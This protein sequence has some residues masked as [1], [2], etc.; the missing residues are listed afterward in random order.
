MDPFE[1]LQ[2]LPHAGLGQ[3]PTPLQKLRR[4][5]EAVGAEIWAKRDDLQDFALAGNKVRKYNLVLGK[6]LADGYDTLVTTGAVQSNSARAGAAA[7]AALGI[8]CV[9]LFSGDPPVE[10][11]GN[12]LLARL[13]G[14]ETR[15][16]GNVSWH[17]LNAGVE[18]IVEEL[19]LGGRKAMS[20]PV[21]CSSPLGA[22]GFAQAFLE[23]DHHLAEI[24]LDPVAVVHSS[25]S[26]GTHA[27]LLVGRALSDRQVRI[28]GVDAAAMFEDVPGSHAKLA[29]Q[30]AALIGL[31]L[32]LEGADLEIIGSQVGDGYGTATDAAVD[33]IGLLA[34]SEAILT[35]PIYSGKG[36]A[37]LAELVADT[38][39][40]I[41]FWHTGGYHALFDPG[42]GSPLVASGR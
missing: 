12:H 17:E 20:A 27:G 16:A 31:D 18:Q 29:N 28:V 8:N 23:L 22:L 30:A 36:L 14:A 6:A 9:L 24:G 1:R 7:A 32:G 39:G 5:S 10:S 15:F 42:H 13:L 19:N 2:E 35:D 33:A 25:T 41:V 26:G 40:P 3:F 38:D 4:F 11:T 34:R 21:G 37:G